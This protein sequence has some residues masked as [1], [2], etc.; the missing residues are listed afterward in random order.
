[1]NAVGFIK[2][3]IKKAVSLPRLPPKHGMTNGEEQIY[4]QHYAKKIFSGEGEIIDLGCWL[5][6]TTIS[7]AA[8]LSKNPSALRKGRLI[9]AYDLF[10]WESWMDKYTTGCLKQYKPGE[11]FLDEYK[12]RVKAYSKLIRI[13]PGDLSKT[14]WSGEPIEFLL[15][16]AMKSWDLAKIIV[17]KFYP[18]LIPGKSYV[19]QQDFKHHYTSWIH[20]V[21]Y[22]LRNYFEPVHNVRNSGSMVFRATEKLNGDFIGLDDLKSCSEQEVNDAFD[23]SLFLVRDDGEYFKD[24]ILAAKVM[25]YIHLDHFSEAK[26]LLE[27]ILAKKIGPP[28]LHFIP[29]QQALA[30]K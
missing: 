10:I 5:G 20:L 25:Y 15:V 26:Q 24:Q 4:F 16:D 2:R 1:M 6:S 28:S 21:H 11:S 9:H 27:G 8:G 3:V 12:T 19:L 23:Y 7:L 14:R 30:A 29:C 17:E 13:Y 18:S 22:R